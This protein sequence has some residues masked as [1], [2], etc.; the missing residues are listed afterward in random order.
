MDL[1]LGTMY[2]GT[3]IDQSTAFAILDRFVESG[4]RTID[5]ANCYSFWTSES[6]R[7][8]QSEQVVGAWLAANPGLREELVI[9]TK[10]GQ[11]PTGDGVE[12]LATEVIVRECRRSRERLGID[13]IDVY[14][15]HS[16]DRSVALD[17]VVA[18]FGTLVTEGSVRRLGASNHATWRLERARA[19]AHELGTE[20]FTA[21]QLFDSFVHPRPNTTVP[22]KDHRFGAV[23][24][25]THDF[26]AE[27][28]LELWLYSPLLQGAYDRSDRP[29]A[30]VYNHAGTT[31]RLAALATVAARHD[32]TASQ[33]VLA[34]L[35]RDARPILGVSSVDQLDAAMAS[36]RLTL[37]EADLAELTSPDPATTTQSPAD[38]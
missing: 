23:T 33:V 18:A 10:V 21:V 8:G 35:A 16:D 20:P 12:G 14:W 22:G 30:D 26:V 37:S 3:R 1:I 25:E 13:T 9:A 38:S 6:G 2:F 11:E 36:A 24:D 32:A 4:G 31:H 17:E 34:Y 19:I 29:L 7:G 27:N 5:T 28:A 15:A